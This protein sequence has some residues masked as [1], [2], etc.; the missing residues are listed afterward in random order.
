[1]SG[2]IGSKFNH[3]GSGLIGSL[4]TDGQHMLSAGAGKT[5]VFETVAAASAYDD[6]AVRSDILT[7]AIKE[8][9]TENRV[10]YNLQNSHIQQFESDD[11]LGTQTDGD[12]T[13]DEY[14]AT[15]FS[16]TTYIKPPMAT[17][18]TNPTVDTGGW[19]GSVTNDALRG[20][21]GT[22]SSYTL[23]YLDYLFDLSQSFRARVFGVTDSSGAQSTMQTSTCRSHTCSILVT[24]DTSE[25]SGA[26]PSIMQD[27][28]NTFYATYNGSVT[29]MGDSVITTAYASTIG[30][31]S[32]STTFSSGT[33]GVTADCNSA[34][35]FA[36]T[37]TSG[38]SINMYGWDIVYTKSTATLICYRREDAAFLTDNTHRITLTEVPTSGRMLFFLGTG[39][40]VQTSQ[41][42]ASNYASMA[43][44]EQSSYDAVTANAT[45][46]LISS[47]QTANASQTK[48]SGV[49]IY[50][51]NEGTATLNTDL[52]MYFSCDGGSNFTQSTMT[53]AGTFSTGILMAKAPEVTCTAG[54]AIQYKLVF[55]N[56]SAGSKETQIHAV[57]LNY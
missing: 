39:C 50:K 38:T 47:S 41:S 48:A 27:N 34:S 29:A 54:T 33:G 36:G 28:A 23:G 20:T 44:T 8:A 35:Y 56:Q 25:S 26:S 11:G 5:N 16:S 32:Y 7:L 46:T 51:N 15:V 12:R 24:T 21:N 19:T 52:K 57:G 31:D 4:G 37:Y 2:I 53:A 10:S 14:W 6:S 18:H 1:M 13:S 22:G 3:R 45:G 43:E 9:M 17:W 55:A 30:S 40:A 42:W 49:V